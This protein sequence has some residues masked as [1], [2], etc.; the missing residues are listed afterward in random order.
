MYEIN[1]Q[2]VNCNTLE[3]SNVNSYLFLWQYGA[4][5]FVQLRQMSRDIS[6]LFTRHRRFGIPLVELIAQQR[7]HY[8]QHFG[9]QLANVMA[10]I[11]LNDIETVQRIASQRSKVRPKQR[12]HPN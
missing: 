6:K 3:Q 5:S 9:L 2:I 12:N 10:Y 1:N 4:N 8:R 11:F 7:V